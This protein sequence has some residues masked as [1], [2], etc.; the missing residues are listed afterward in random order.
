MPRLVE[1]NAKAEGGEKSESISPARSG[2]LFDPRV[3][4]RHLSMRLPTPDDDDDD[5]DALMT[6]TDGKHREADCYRLLN[7]YSRRDPAKIREDLIA[8]E[9]SFFNAVV[10]LKNGAFSR[11]PLS[12]TATV[13]A[14]P[15]W[16]ESSHL[17]SYTYGCVAATANTSLKGDSCKRRFLAAQL[18][19]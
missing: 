3:S 17:F 11:E 6:R 19:S 12:T 2:A 4:G 9:L 14:A 5:D 10:S 7:C 15:R 16:S 1:E 18:G 8:R 13:C